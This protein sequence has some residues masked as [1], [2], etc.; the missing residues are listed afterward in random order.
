MHPPLSSLDSPIEREECETYE[1]YN[2]Q[3]QNVYARKPNVKSIQVFSVGWTK[4]NSRIVT[5][6][7]DAVGN[8]HRNQKAEQRHRPYEQ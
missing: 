7:H 8:E 3:S 2:K 4:E 6:R 1:S 5:R